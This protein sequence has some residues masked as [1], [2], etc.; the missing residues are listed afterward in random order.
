[1]DDRL[2]GKGFVRIARKIRQDSYLW[3]KPLSKTEAWID[4]IMMAAHEKT[5]WEGVNGEH[6]TVHRS[7]FSR[8]RRISHSAR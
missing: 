4:L 7:E 3:G 5:K 1:M 8:S 6:I 2:R